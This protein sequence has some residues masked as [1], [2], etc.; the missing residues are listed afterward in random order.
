MLGGNL[1]QVWFGPPGLFPAAVWVYSAEEA[2]I[3]PSADSVLP[4]SYLPPSSCS[5]PL[6]QGGKPEAPKALT[7]Q[8]YL[9][10]ASPSEL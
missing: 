6:G 2:D 1:D 4:G 10:A 7:R 8:G 9:S 3:T 5:L